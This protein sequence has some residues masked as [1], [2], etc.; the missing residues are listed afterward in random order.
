MSVMESTVEHTCYHVIYICDNRCEDSRCEDSHPRQPGPVLSKKRKT[1][2][3]GSVSTG[4][5]TMKTTD[6]T[7][8]TSGVLE[9]LHYYIY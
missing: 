3:S 5:H 1:F 9:M 8:P 4:K 6:A 2:R 7:K